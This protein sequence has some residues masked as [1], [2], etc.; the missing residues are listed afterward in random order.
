MSAHC[1][2]VG[3]VIASLLYCALDTKWTLF[4]E[5][6]TCCSNVGAADIPTSTQSTRATEYPSR[7]CEGQRLSAGVRVRARAVFAVQTRMRR[8]GCS[9]GAQPSVLVRLI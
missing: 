8:T 1:I 7:M 9:M 6:T 5:T 2:T 4:E 3:D